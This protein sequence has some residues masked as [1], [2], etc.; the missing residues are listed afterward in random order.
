MRRRSG[1]ALVASIALAVAAASTGL[2]SAHEIPHG[3]SRP[4][5]AAP[6]TRGVVFVQSNDL[7]RNAVLAFRRDAGGMLTAAGSFATGGK[8]GAQTDNP[9][10]PLASQDSL[11]FDKAHSVL[12]AVNAGSNSITTF[13]V[14]GDRLADRRVLASGGDFPTSVAVSGDHAYVLNAGGRTNVSG[15]RFDGAALSPIE[16]STRELGITNDAVPLFTASP[17]QVGFTPD[18]QHLVV[19]T[20]SAGTIDVF[21]VGRRGRLS[22]TAVSTK[23]VGN[24]PFSFVFDA[25]GHLLV[26]EAE[27]SGVSSYTV[28]EDG[29]LDP[30]TESVVSGQQVLCWIA[31]AGAFFYG[32]NPGSSTVS[33]YTVDAAGTVTLGGKDGVIAQAGGAAAAAEVA[34]AAGTKPA[35]APGAGPID[36]AATPDGGQL[37]VQNTLAGT[38]ETFTVGADGSLTLAATLDKGLPVF[39]DGS[40]MEGIAVI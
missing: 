4:G 13:Q 27:K 17:P 12:I 37:F 40:G 9:F 25:A 36:L 24:V 32:T 30:I 14:R 23:S 11:V 35:K 26:T 6:E 21:A 3:K 29:S 19:T 2:A 33:L 18:G 34:A 15:F 31:R 10:D 28:N 38:I 20:K 5:P 7:D 16:D 39:A 22:A 1:M 8:G